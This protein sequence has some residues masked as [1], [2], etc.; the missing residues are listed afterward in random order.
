MQEL[1]TYLPNTTIVHLIDTGDGHYTGRVHQLRNEIDELPSWAQQRHL[2]LDRDGVL[3]VTE[4]NRKNE[5]GYYGD[6]TAVWA[7][8]LTAVLCN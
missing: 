1:E 8:A 3:S 7:R 4:V 6:P 2:F 5:H